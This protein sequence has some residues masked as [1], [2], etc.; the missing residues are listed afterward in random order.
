MDVT[1][2]DGQPG[3]E[4]PSSPFESSDLTLTIDRVE[5]PPVTTD[6]ISEKTSS[7][8]A[9][10]SWADV[11]DQGVS[12]PVTADGSSLPECKARPPCNSSEACNCF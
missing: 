3:V 5:S 6:D 10:K 12:P 1:P 11:V 8:L 4:G 7:P 2:T 9:S